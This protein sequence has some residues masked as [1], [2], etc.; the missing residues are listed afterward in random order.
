MDLDVGQIKQENERLKQLFTEKAAENLA[1]E[2]QNTMFKKQLSYYK[3][4]YEKPQGFG[5]NLQNQETEDIICHQETPNAETR[6]LIGTAHRR[7]T[8]N[9]NSLIAKSILLPFIIDEMAKK[10]QGNFQFTNRLSTM[11]PISDWEYVI[12]CPNPDFNKKGRSFITPQDALG[13]FK[14]SFKPEFSKNVK[15]FRMN[16]QAELK[17]FIQ[18]F[19]SCGNTNENGSTKDPGAQSNNF[20]ALMRNILLV[21]LGL[22]LGLHTKQVMSSNGQYIYILVCP[23]DSDLQN[24]AEAI[25]YNLQMEIGEVDLPS[26]EPCDKNLRPLRI[27]QIPDQRIKEKLKDIKNEFSDIMDMLKTTESDENQYPGLEVDNLW[28]TYLMYLDEFQKGLKEMFLLDIPEEEKNACVNKIMRKSIEIANKGRQKNMRLKNLWEHMGF[29]KPLSPY[30]GYIR[31]KKFKNIWKKYETQ[32]KQKKA[33][34]RSIDRLKLLQSLISRQVDLHYLAQKEIIHSF[35][36]LKS[37]YELK[38][39]RQFT[40]F[41][42]DPNYEDLSKKLLN[43]LYESSPKGL[44]NNWGSRIAFGDLPIYKIRNYFGEKIGLYFAFINY[45]GKILC[46][47]S[48]TGIVVFVLQRIYDPEDNIIIIANVL[49]CIYVSVWATVFIEFWKRKEN[50]LAI[51]WGQTGYEDDEVPR[52][53]FHGTTRRSPIDDEMDDVFF[54]PKDRYKYF[55]LSILITSAFIGIVISAVLGIIILR[56]QLI[57]NLMFGG[58]DLAG[59]ICSS[60]NAVQIQIFNFIFTSIATRLN[61][62]ENHRT[63]SDYESSLIIKT[64]VFQFVN[65]FFSLFYIGF[66]KTMTEGCI[67][68]ENGQKVRV[69]GASCMDE[70]Y[71][72]FITIFTISFIKNGLELGFPYIKAKHMERSFRRTSSETFDYRAQTSKSDIEILRDQIDKQIQLPAYIS[73]DVDGTLGDYLEISILYGYITLFAVAFPLSGILTFIAVIIETYVDRYKLLHLV[74][75]PLPLGAKN[76]NKWK[77]ILVFNSIATIVTNAAIICFTMPTFTNWESAENNKFLVF[78]CFCIFMLLL[79]AAIAFGV[80]DIPLKYHLILKR[81]QKIVQKFIKGWEVVKA[82][83]SDNIYVN[84]MIYCVQ[85]SE[86]NYN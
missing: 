55:F 68:S 36:P 24:E 52:P 56:W 49:Y 13:Y 9:K 50:C 21:K 43:N 25:N 10:F 40:D 38:G 29:D 67:V 23:D 34:F 19:N 30:F 83:G 39:E 17:A 27:L 32:H 81:H 12:V 8:F 6:S 15:D 53:Q 3:N 51:K 57:N 63:Q 66:F 45:F 5:S 80:P 22:H 28:D 69:K 65:S 79:R 7:L 72:Q 77:T 11:I 76:I 64:Y 61:D 60:I 82:K 42:D 1:L 33:I 20:L 16:Q 84:P 54:D 46:I 70:L 2:S 4:N 31:D 71:T 75:R 78:A 85:K 18:V 48:F 86:Y 62:L 37:I 35:F 58:F 73:R 14:K 47:P 44:L 59:P 74:R 41:R 26:L